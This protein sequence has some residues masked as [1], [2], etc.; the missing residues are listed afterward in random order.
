MPPRL[1]ADRYQLL[2][3]VSRAPDATY[4]QAADTR[5]DRNVMLEL[6]RPEVASDPDAV[7]R[8]RDSMRVTAR[9]GAGP[10]GRLLDGGTD[11]HQRLP[12]AVFEWRDTGPMAVVASP[13]VDEPPASAARRAPTRYAAEPPGSAVAARPAPRSVQSPRQSGPQR[14]GSGSRN[15]AL[16]VVLTGVPVLV[17]IVAV[18]RVLTASG[19]PVGN[20]LAVPTGTVLVSNPVVTP[21][22]A[23]VGPTATTV[24]PVVATTAPSPRAVTPTVAGGGERVRIANT[25]GIGVALRDSPGGQRLP[26]KGY[27]EG[28]TV[29]V[30][31]RQGDW[32]HIRGD[33][34]REGWVLSVT[35]PAAGPQAAPSPPSR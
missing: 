7:E 20:L 5:L 19:P 18:S 23:T 34:G 6:M 24:R 10:H 31:E 27:D 25:D 9:G 29:T 33:D 2:R 35:V 17:G 14:S 26:G 4:W 16:P 12:F 13:Q 3:E 8:F 28:V 32:T 30:L 15:W 1:I 22:P 11:G 21:P